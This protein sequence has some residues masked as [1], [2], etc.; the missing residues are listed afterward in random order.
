MKTARIIAILLLAA[1][2]TFAAAGGATDLAPAVN[3][4]AVDLHHALCANDGNLFFSP[5]SISYALGMTRTGAR[6]TTASEMDRVLHLSGGD[7]D[8]AA[9]GRLM[10]DL[11][12]ANEAYTLRL[13]NRLY[14]QKG[15]AFRSEFLG[16]VGEQFRGG[17]EEV[18]YMTDAEGARLDI[19]TWVSEQTAECIPELLA[20]GVLND[21]TRLV[22]VNAIYFLGDWLIPFPAENTRPRPFH[23]ADSETTDVPMMSETAVFGYAEPE[24]LQVLALPYKGNELE[25]VVL[26]PDEDEGLGGLAER[27]TA[28]ALAKWLAAPA[29]T[30]ALVVLPKF[31][32]TSGFGLSS[33]LAELGMPTAF[34]ENDADFTGMTTDE[35]LFIDNVVHK[36]YVRVDETGTEAAAATAVIMATDS[37]PMPPEARFIADRPFLFLIRHLS[38]LL[39]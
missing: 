34:D 38:V 24:G 39:V 2:P 9:Y 22:L 3:A 1:L 8:A 37:A 14:G 16:T 32:F 12:D 26:L 28:D 36:A 17:F 13:A 10:D 15:M 30:H 6:G 21:R 29:P 35:H 20:Q 23:L 31:E 25:M 27:L 5:A 7:E 18:D 4:F 19:D 11:L 33:I